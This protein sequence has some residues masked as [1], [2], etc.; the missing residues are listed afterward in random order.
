MSRCIR[1]PERARNAGPAQKIAGIRDPR[2]SIGQHQCMTQDQSRPLA[3]DPVGSIARSRPTVRGTASVR[4]V[5]AKM[6]EESCSAVVVNGRDG[7]VH[8]VTERDIVRALAA[9]ADPDKEWAVD[10]M[11]VEL[12]SLDPDQTVRDAAQM[13]L[14]AV[15]RHVVV[16]DPDSPDDVAMVSIRDVLAPFINSTAD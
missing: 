16:D 14:D 2:P 5:A 6:I 8:V 4:Q 11:S 12:R 1:E 3:S 7:Q 10:V 15:I 9:D 13:M